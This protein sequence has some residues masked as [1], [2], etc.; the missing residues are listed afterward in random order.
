[1]SKQRKDIPSEDCWNV[2]ALYSDLQAWEDHFQEVRGN[3][4]RPSPEDPRWPEIYAYRGCL[5]DNAETVKSA[6]KAIISLERQL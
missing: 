1:M 6:L 5:G 3:D 4:D 2:E